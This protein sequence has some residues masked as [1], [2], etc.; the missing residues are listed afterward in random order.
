VRENDDAV[1]RGGHIVTISYTTE[2]FVRRAVGRALDQYQGGIVCSACLVRMALERLHA[3][4]RRSEIERA[5]EKV[6]EVPGALNRIS[7][8]PCA[9]C[10]RAM[11]CLGPPHR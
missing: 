6:F 5:M 2:G 4:W 8:G 11:P 9:R 10:N 1:P 3:G 7:T